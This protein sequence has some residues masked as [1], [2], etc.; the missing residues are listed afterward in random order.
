MACIDCKFLEELKLGGRQRLRED[1][2]PVYVCRYD[3]PQITFDNR[4]EPVLSMWP[5]IDEPE[6]DWCSHFEQKGSR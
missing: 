6:T 4:G 5:Y 1:W 2:E 3:P